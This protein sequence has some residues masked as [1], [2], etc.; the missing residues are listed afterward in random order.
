[1]GFEVHGLNFLKYVAREQPLGSV[2]T[3]GRQSLLLWPSQIAEVLGVPNVPDFGN[4][5]EEL[6]KQY[7]GAELV[8]SYDYSDY[9]GATF[10]ADMNKPLTPIR[11]YDTVIDYGSLEHVYNVPQGLANVSQLCRKSG[12]IVHISPSNNFCGHGFWQFSPELFF[13]LYSAANGYAETEVFLADVTCLDQWFKVHPPSNGKRAEAVSSA[14][15]HVMCKARKVSDSCTS[16]VQQSDYVQ[17]WKGEQQPSSETL[18]GVKKFVRSKPGLLRGVWAVRG[19]LHRLKNPTSLSD[20]N[21]HLKKVAV[22]D[23]LVG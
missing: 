1:M 10:T 3:I 22:T 6:L 23:L 11:Q 15:L 17:A 5:C 12:R 9:E 7:F 2:A 16:E 4:Y 21:P 14:P 18:S 13:S 19:R 20:R 8:D